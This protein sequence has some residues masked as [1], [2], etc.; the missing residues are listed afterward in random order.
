[1]VQLIAVQKEKANHMNRNELIDN[2]KKFVPAPIRVALRKN[3]DFTAYNIHYRANRNPFY[4]DPDEYLF[5][6]S[7]PVIGIIKEFYQYH[8]SYIAACRDLKVNYRLIDIST[9]DWIEKVENSNC[10]AFLA[11]PSAGTSIWKDMY[12]NRLRILKEDLNKI[13]FPDPKSLWIFENKLRMRDW[14]KANQIR[15]PE[16]WVFYEKQKALRFAEEANLPIVYKTNI[17]AS[18]SGVK[19]IRDRRKLVHLI[20]KVFKNGVVPKGHHPMDKDWGRIM[21]QQYLPDVNE[22]RMI[23][24]ADSYFGYRKERVGDFHSGSH[25]WSWLDPGEKLLN[26]T[27]EICEKG[28]FKSMNVDVFLTKN[29]ELY[30][31]ELQ[32]VFGAT[33]PAEMLKIN[34]VEGRYLYKNG[35]WTF[36]P[37]D[38]SKNQCSN[39]RVQY[40]LSL[41]G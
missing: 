11:W 24:I 9:H 15:I 7:G 22:W 4:N 25:A 8:K 21:L 13:V 31:N 19:I 20:Q 41:I 34:G 6:R 3:I 14:L 16:S 1:M 27:R 12:D 17:G 30:V 29:G 33:T 38:F 37:G 2:F 23:R 5:E 35:D 32:A 18:A 39:L 40:L 26:F 36:E 10:D 28:N